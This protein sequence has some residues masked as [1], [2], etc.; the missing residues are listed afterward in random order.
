MVA[1]RVI[2]I[3]LLAVLINLSVAASLP[4]DEDPN[5]QAGNPAA[6]E[7][8]PT[9]ASNRLIVK[10]HNVGARRLSAN[11]HRM[12][13]D[14][15]NAG[16]PESE[17]EVEKSLLELSRTS[18]LISMRHLFF[19]ERVTDSAE[20]SAL[21][22]SEVQRIRT[23]YA[24][25]SRRAAAE[26]V[27]DLSGYF[28]LEFDGNRD[29]KKLRAEFA[30]N[31]L[32]E[33]VHLD[34]V[35]HIDSEPND[36]FLNSV[37]SW[38]Q[39]EHDLWGLKA[40]D[41]ESAWQISKGQGITVAVIDTGLD[42]THPDIAHQYWVNG[43]ETAENGIDDD[44]N[45]FTDDVR[46]WDFANGDNDP[47]DDSR[48][49]HG[50]H[51]SG[52]I[53]AAGDNGIGIIGVAPEARIMVVKGSG[54]N[55]SAEFS[56]MAESIYYAVSN[57]A[58]VVNC[59]WGPGTSGVIPLAVEQAIQLG[60]TLGV[61]F[62]FASGNDSNVVAS[63]SPMN[64]KDVLTVGASLPDNQRMWRSNWGRYQ[65]ILAPGGSAD[66]GPLQVRAPR[67]SILSLKSK[68]FS[69]S[70]AANDVTVGEKY[71]RL[72]GTSMAAPHVAGTAA[73]ILACREDL[74][75]DDVASLLHASAD[76][77]FPEGFDLNS[78][79]GRLNAGK[80]VSLARHK[81]PAARLTEPAENTQL[82]DDG[83]AISICGIVSGERLS[84]YQLFLSS[85]DQLSEMKALTEPQVKGVNGELHSLDT[86]E[87]PIG[88]YLIRLIAKDI[89]GNSF[90]DSVQVFKESSQAITIPHDNLR[91]EG[92]V[93]SGRFVAWIESDPEDD[94]LSFDVCVFNLDSQTKSVVASEVT[95]PSGLAVSDQFVAY[96]MGT[97]ENE[98]LI[99]LKD[100][101]R[102]DVPEIL[103]RS[104]GGLSFF[105]LKFSGRNLMWH[106]TD[107]SRVMVCNVLTGRMTNVSGRV[108]PE[109]PDINGEQLVWM[110][111]VQNVLH[112][113]QISQ[114][115]AL[116]TEDG[117]VRPKSNPR[118]SGS[119]VVWSDGAGATANLVKDIVAYDMVTQTS[120]ILHRDLQ[121]VQGPA[122]SGNR[123]VW[124]DARNGNMDVY[125]F[126]LAKNTESRLTSSPDFEG[127][128]EIVGSTVMW[129]RLERTIT[130]DQG[131][132]TPTIRVLKLR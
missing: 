77:R 63:Q 99:R 59:S 39:T 6:D 45:G 102:D 7:D 3:Q 108:Q 8:A 26:L 73:L 69:T 15:A 52:T 61:V 120:R 14:I 106:D 87:L 42:F 57:G 43:D 67:R 129:T 5:G 38:G 90:E 79:F 13:K 127:L 74:T 35:A 114:R 101:T 46:G 122:I 1:E 130:G 83:G 124:A 131:E 84:S 40:I 105:S 55:G 81:P 62:V 115:T 34:P 48:E 92:A 9:V 47:T 17:S 88:C 91:Q 20:A 96:S 86:S 2:V 21:Q 10:F 110:T 98:S 93:T 126:D 75:I 54:A 132:Y 33:S 78:G 107:K 30:K 100:F 37:G 71:V 53:A 56:T 22:A 109:S 19:G 24:K 72:S 118:V 128:P 58:D 113:D 44:K 25:R 111:S 41:A 117:P 36:P 68:S 11:A 112:F 94:E 49:G 50:T 29:I 97:E 51:V 64:M 32:I 80:A 95:K 27:P 103:E 125:M 18:G 23:K 85:L 123:I 12:M 119:T 104:T 76:D 70:D 89:D 116:L 82:S 31:P 28:V 66:V 65:D 4:A 60:R 16:V 121:L